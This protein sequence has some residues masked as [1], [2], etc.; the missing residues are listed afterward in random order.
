MTAHIEKRIELKKELPLL[1]RQLKPFEANPTRFVVLLHVDKK[2]ECEVKV[3]CTTN[4]LRSCVPS[5]RNGANH[6]SWF[7]LDAFA[8][9]FEI[10]T[11]RR[12]VEN[13]L[14]KI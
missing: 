8:A 6:E 12:T 3:L 1:R 9:G 7:D 10:G 5:C 4:K 11:Q 2:V 14:S 13:P